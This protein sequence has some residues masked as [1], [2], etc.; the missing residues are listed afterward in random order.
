[1]AQT[2]F[3]EAFASKVARNTWQRAVTPAITNNAYEGEVKEIGDRVN[4]IMMLGDSVLQDYVTG[5][6]MSTVSPVDTEAT[7]TIEKR[8]AWN[9]VI[10][11]LE[12]VFAYA[13]D[14]P[15]TVSEKYTKQLEREI[16]S[17][18]LAKF[19]DAKNWV[20]YN[21]RVTGSSRDTEASIATSATGGTIT[22]Q[23]Q[24]GIASNYV[25]PVELGDGTSAFSGF[26]A[27]DTGK[28]IRLTSGTSWATPFYLISG[29][30]DSTNVTV[31]NWDGAISG[32]DIP[33]GD[34]L[35]GLYGAQEFT[36]AGVYNGDGKPTSE[37]GWG[38]ELM[39]AYATT[40]S[41]STIYDQVTECAQ[42]LDE[43]EMPD[44][45][46]HMTAP[47][48]V[49]TA[50]RQ[51]SELQPAIAM[52]YEGVVING[53]VGRVGGIDVHSATG[54]RVSTR[55]EHSKATAGAANEGADTVLES[56]DLAHQIP[57]NHI[58]MCTFAYKWA[59]SRVVDAEDQFARKYQG[60]H[61]YGALVPNIRRKNGVILY[62]KV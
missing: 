47:P 31:T 52:A 56:G 24:A 18:T 58:D 6:D 51:A 62:A 48:A 32:E 40:I 27:A 30:T 61:L 55:V 19:P 14:V 54:F 46:R 4:I 23:A 15:D 43:E 3:G 22:V 37:G 44:T 59:E 42:R 60:L 16:D 41:S 17:Y 34:V 28:Y 8:K 35:R 21:M 2:N 36:G 9:F 1:M 20:G 53:R 57:V 7:L 25:A 5:T 13:Q 39:A 29:V 26:T 45:D 11:R 33:A 49:I 50:L 10:D 12:Q 38:Y